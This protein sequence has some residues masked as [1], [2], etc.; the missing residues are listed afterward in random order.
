MTSLQRKIL[1]IDDEQQILNTTKLSLQA[2]GLKGVITLSDSTLAMTL[3]T[4]E[5]VA[6]IVLDLRMPKLSG[7]ELLPQIVKAYPDIPIILV[8]A[9]DEIDTVVEAMKLGAFD[10]LVKP[11][12]ASRL[13]AAVRKALEMRSMAN[14]LSSLKQYML[15]DRL[16]H[17]DVFASIITGLGFNLLVQQVVLSRKTPDLVF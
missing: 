9:N 16:D 2:S 17:P 4:Q 11:V 6:V 1:L 8:T 15:A 12:E 13:V 7:L 10:Y 5:P 14:E 3:L